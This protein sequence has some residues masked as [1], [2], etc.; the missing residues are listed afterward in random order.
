M[1]KLLKKAIYIIPLIIG[2][3]LVVGIATGG[4]DKGVN[5]AQE[6]VKETKEDKGDSTSEDN[7]DEIHSDESSETR[8]GGDRKGIN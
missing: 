2:V 7:L 5:K 8:R 3:A 1:K 6:Y 4:L